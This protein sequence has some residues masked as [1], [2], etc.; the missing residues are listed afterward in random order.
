MTVK[1]GDENATSFEVVFRKE[2]MAL[3]NCTLSTLAAEGLYLAHDGPVESNRL[4]YQPQQFFEFLIV[5]VKPIA[6][7][8]GADDV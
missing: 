7:G 5:V 4:I 1:F 8:D 3:Q 6:K 2:T